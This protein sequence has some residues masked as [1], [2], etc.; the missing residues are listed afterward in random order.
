MRDRDHAVAVL[1]AILAGR[2]PRPMMDMVA[3]NVGLAL[4]LLGDDPD[5]GACMAC[6][7]EAVAAG[8]GLKVVP[9]AA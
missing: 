4:W 5:M 3:L 1:K 2:G 8:T 9:H 6:A 7:R